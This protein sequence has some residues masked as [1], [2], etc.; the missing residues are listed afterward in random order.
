MHAVPVSVGVSQTCIGIDDGELSVESSTGFFMNDASQATCS[1]TLTQWRYCYY[2]GQT[3]PGATARLGLYRNVGTDS[4]ELASGSVTLVTVS[5]VPS[6]PSFVCGAVAPPQNV[7]VMPGDIIGACLP[8]ASNAIALLSVWPGRILKVPKSEH[9]SS[10]TCDTLLQSASSD[11]NWTEHSYVLHMYAD[12][13][14]IQHA[15]TPV[16]ALKFLTDSAFPSH[17]TDG[18][19]VNNGGCSHMCT[20]IDVVGNVSCT[21]GK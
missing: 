19:G 13:G 7:A 11:G 1:G 21:D 14:E 10:P 12:I 5:S 8:S 4:Y 18:C 20:P 17:H 6:S 15:F 9:F 16:C 3:Q 2:T